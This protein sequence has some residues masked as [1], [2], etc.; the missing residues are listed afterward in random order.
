MRRLL[1]T[2]GLVVVGLGGF[3]TH[4]NAYFWEWMDKL[5]GPRFGG[6][7]IDYR[8]W[9]K[10]ENPGETAQV[11]VSRKATLQSTLLLYKFERQSK[12]NVASMDDHEMSIDVVQSLS[13]RQKAALRYF[14]GAVQMET[15][16]LT[17][18][19]DALDARRKKSG[20]DVAEFLWRAELAEAQAQSQLKWALH[21]LESD[22][23]AADRRKHEDE[24]ANTLALITAAFVPGITISLCEARQDDRLDRYVSLNVGWGFERDTRSRFFGIRLLGRDP[25]ENRQNAVVTL[26][27]SY[28][29]VVQPW[30]TAGIG[31][32]V[33]YFSS[34]QQRE[35]FRKFY[36]E[37]YIVDIRPVAA[38]PKWKDEALAH[39]FF[40]RFGAIIFP[41][42]FEAGRFTR[43]EPVGP[44]STQYPAEFLRTWGF[45]ADLEP[46]MRKWLNKWS[47]AP[48]PKG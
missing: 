38:I 25:D 8:V 39:T 36:I 35:S 41:Q 7:F 16:A 13:A 34:T 22:D 27:A 42:G 28:H 24:L 2:L 43:P 1:A 29:M 3:P 26:G 21:V 30:L 47:R 32:G 17:S 33:A 46:L 31:G 20:A 19:Q 15:L 37:P 12:V 5:S 11:L 10:Y 9:C 45:H 48:M 44:L 14:D 40:F 4:A 6:Y 18:I 23:N